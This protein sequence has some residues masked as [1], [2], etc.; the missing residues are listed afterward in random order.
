MS[1]CGGPGVNRLT[2]PSGA[3]TS[4]RGC[5]VTASAA[6]ILVASVFPF[7]AR[8]VGQCAVPVRLLPCVSLGEKE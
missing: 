2:L 8:S 3:C 7:D 5:L 6:G 4:E 1:G